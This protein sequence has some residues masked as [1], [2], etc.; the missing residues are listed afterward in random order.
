MEPASSPNDPVFFLNHCNA[1]R[2]WAA[3][4]EQNP[5]APYLPPADAEPADELFRHRLEDP[6]YSALTES[7]PRVSQML[8]VSD[9]YTY[10]TLD[11]A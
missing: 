6:I 8:N 11:V 3:W 10:D 1:D 9:R 5:N 7:E 4:Q 2:I